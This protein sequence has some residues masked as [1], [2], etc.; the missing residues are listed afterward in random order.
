MEH[1]SNND[2]IVIG[3]LG[4]VTEELIQREEDLEKRRRVETI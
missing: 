2:T 1:E 4:W 3:A